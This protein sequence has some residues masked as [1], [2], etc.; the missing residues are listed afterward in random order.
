MAVIRNWNQ[1]TPYVGHESAIIWSIFAAAGS[2]GLAAEE[3]T[4]EGLL[5]FTRHMMQSG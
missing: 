5:A 4:L 1:A 2:E 3:A